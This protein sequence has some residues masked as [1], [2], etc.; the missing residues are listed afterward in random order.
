MARERVEHAMQFIAGRIFF[1]SHPHH[2]ITLERPNKPCGRTSSTTA[3]R[4]KIDTRP[5]SGETSEVRLT[6]TPTSTP[7]TTAPVS[8]PIPPT[9]VTTN[10]SASRLTPISGV[11]DCSGAESIPDNPAIPV[12]M[13]KT[14]SQIFDVDAEHA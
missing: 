13:P 1:Q 14:I 10:A 12:P 8:E 2:P 3:I 7:A 4:M 5:A 6:T 9:T 11:T